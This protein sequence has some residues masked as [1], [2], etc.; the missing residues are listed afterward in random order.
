MLNMLLC[1]II[2]HRIVCWNQFRET[3]DLIQYQLL[4]RTLHCL[5]KNFSLWDVAKTDMKPI[6]LTDPDL[7]HQNI[8]NK[9]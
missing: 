8:K 9:K 5:T 3:G 2:H 1:R 7:K 4:Q 6:F